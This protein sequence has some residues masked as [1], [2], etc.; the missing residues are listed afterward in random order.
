VATARTSGR[1]IEIKLAVGSAASARR[2]LR[3]CGF[4]ILQPRALESNFVFDTPGLRL[5]KS[6]VLLRVREARRNATL[7]YKGPAKWKA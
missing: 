6:G 3:E 2:L 1:E 5:R 4:R 7:T